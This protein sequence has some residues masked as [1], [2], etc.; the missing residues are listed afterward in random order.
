MQARRPHVVFVL[1]P[2]GAGKGTI[3]Q[4]IVDT[5]R[6]V[7][8]SAGDLLRKERDTPGSAYTELILQCINDGKIVPVKIT[9]DLLDRAMRENGSSY[10]LI[11]G[12]PRNHDNL[13]G[14][15]KAM[16]EKVTLD[17]VIHLQCDS[18]VCMERCLRRGNQDANT[19]AGRR[20]DD[21]MQTLMARLNSYR[22]DTLPVIGEYTKL[23][24]VRRIDAARSPDDVFAD[25]AGHF[26]A[27]FPDLPQ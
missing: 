26:R 1:G 12:F 11:D 27:A 16:S 9:C 17:F 7:H 23:G 4:R 3:C 15:T 5:F 19:I 22:D 8:L 10:F 6:F 24:L 20:S 18:D 14:W 25:V 2:P 13:E 21:N